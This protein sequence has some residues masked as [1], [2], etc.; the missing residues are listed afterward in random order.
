[1]TDLRKAVREIGFVEIATGHP[2][3]GGRSAMIS[4]PALGLGAVGVGRT[5]AEARTRAAEK[6]YGRYWQSR[7]EADAAI[8]KALGKPA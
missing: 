3:S 4:H 6:A 1:M 2:T 5:L 7:L 8:K